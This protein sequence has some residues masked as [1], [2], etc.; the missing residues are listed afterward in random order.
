MT[1]TEELLRFAKA[2]SDE[3]NGC[4]TINGRFGY[5]VDSGEDQAFVE[6]DPATIKQ[7]VELVRLQHE[8]LRTCGDGGIK[9]SHHYAQWFNED[10]VREAL[11]AYERFEKGKG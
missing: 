3:G 11:A 10:D 8:A 2:I 5:W 4:D 9:F 6:F 7:L 1:K